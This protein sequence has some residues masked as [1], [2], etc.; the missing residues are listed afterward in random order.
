MVVG[1]FTVLKVKNCFGKIHLMPT[2]ARNSVTCS[3]S[4][5]PK[6]VNITV[7]ERMVSQSLMGGKRASDSL[8]FRQDNLHLQKHFA[9]KD[10]KT[11]S[12]LD[13]FPFAAEISTCLYNVCFFLAN[14]Y[15]TF[16]RETHFYAENLLCK[17]V[18]DFPCRRMRG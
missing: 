4:F 7:L 5:F 2:L 14:P 1:K 6:T 16:L 12:V 9:S 18:V 8:Y 17:Q 11:L 13:F 10:V 15:A 3:N